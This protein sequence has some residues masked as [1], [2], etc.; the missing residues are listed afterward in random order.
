MNIS[1]K[2]LYIFVF[3]QD[4]LSAEKA[5]YIKDNRS[6]FEAEINMLEEI[7][8]NTQSNVE[9]SIIDRIHDKIENGNR[10][11]KITLERLIIDNGDDH[12]ILAADSPETDSNKTETYIDK[13]NLFLSKILSN[14]KMNRIYIFRNSND[15]IY[16]FTVTLL[17]SKDQF[18]INS[19]E[20]PLIIAPPQV[21][22][23]LEIKF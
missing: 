10:Q 19:A 5:E 23:K 12:L 7:R 18:T 16:D 20:L 22:E 8:K 13:E 4:K 15:E 17:P 3:Y 21:I 2:D 14:D 11:N 9:Q 1:E 6:K